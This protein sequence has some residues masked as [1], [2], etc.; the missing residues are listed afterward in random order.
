MSQLPI[1]A[2]HQHQLNIP[3]S[4]TS[5]PFLTSLAL[6][7]ILTRC[8]SPRTD[9]SDEERQTL[10]SPSPP[11]N[12][13]T[14]TS[15]YGTCTEILH[16]GTHS[17]VRLYARKAS[18][19]SPRQ[20]HVVKILRCSSNA[21]TRA[22]HRLE[23]T[24]S[25]AI[26][27]PNLLNTID[28]LQNDRGETCLVMPY[29]AGGDLNTLIATAPAQT[30]QSEEANC[31]FK[32]ITRAVAYLHENFIAHRGLKTE[33]ILLTAHGAVKVADFGSAEWLVPEVGPG[34][35]G[36]TLTLGGGLR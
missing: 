5:P 1:H 9:S 36:R 19:Q 35:E 27:H 28:T 23:Q 10:L 33:N 11:S 7:T 21:Y 32:Q 15:Q 8:W 29:C 3:Q 13:P 34:A 26:S 31:F 6:P 17:S 25:T 18:P 4:K 30:L 24:L 22:T 2:A 12:A 14:L 20:L 16:Y